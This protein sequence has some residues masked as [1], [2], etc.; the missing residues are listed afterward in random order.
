MIIVLGPGGGSLLRAIGT[1]PIGLLFDIQIELIVGD[2][3]QLKEIVRLSF[4]VW[5]L[6]PV[7]CVR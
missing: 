4:V 3:V 5:I 1:I 2:V 7:V 6:F